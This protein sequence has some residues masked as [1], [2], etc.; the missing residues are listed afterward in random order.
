[1][2]LLRTLLTALAFAGALFAFACF[3][4]RRVLFPAPPLPREG[5]WPIGETVQRVWLETPSARSEALLLAAEPRGG[6]PAPLLLYAHGNGEL[7]DYWAG[8]F[9]PLRAAGVSVLL[10][11]YPGYGRSS[12]SPS[13]ASIAQSMVA[14]FDWAVAQPGVDR[15]RV[16]GYGRSL[17][18]GAVCAL[19]RERALAALVLESTFTSVTALAAELFHLPGFLVRDPF[20][21]LAAVGAFPGPVLVLHGER[22]EM[23]PFEHARRLHAAN[24]RARLHGLPCGHNDCAR[25]WPLIQDFL[26]T[27]IR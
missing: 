15:A 6:E 26:I 5:E 11:E 16:A 18:G 13:Q 19:A 4:G 1:M 9:E 3:A 25:P 8:E 20:D 21:N 12:G 14:A 23:I 10:V 2:T 22:D 24:P 7:I 27:A 17:G